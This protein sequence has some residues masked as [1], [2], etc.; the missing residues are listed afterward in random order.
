MMWSVS[1][2]SLPRLWWIQRIAALRSTIWAG[3]LPIHVPS[4]DCASRP[5]APGTTTTQPAARASSPL[6]T[7]CP[8]EPVVSPAPEATPPAPGPPTEPSGALS[9]SDGVPPPGASE[10]PR[11][12]APPPDAPPEAVA[13]E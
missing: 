5:R 9:P 11:P 4:E 1:P 7:G 13:E 6:S 12:G 3:A 2:G 8:S 10:E